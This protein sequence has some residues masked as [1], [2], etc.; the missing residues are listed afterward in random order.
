[1]IA[2]RDRATPSM[3]DGINILQRIADR[4][5]TVLVLDRDFLDLTST[6]GKGILAFLS[7]IAQDQHERI[8]RRAP[9]G[10]KQAAAPDVKMGRG[11]ALTDHRADRVRERVAVGET[12]A[13]HG[14]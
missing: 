3:M 10:R 6:M 13:I 14:A 9:G 1:M 8:V 11:K 5:A 7:A 2:E 4:G 12:Q